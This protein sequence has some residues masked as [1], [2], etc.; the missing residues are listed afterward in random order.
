VMIQRR[1]PGGTPGLI[2]GTRRTEP[3]RS[4]GRLNDRGRAY[5][6]PFRGITYPR[7]MHGTLPFSEQQALASLRGG[8]AAGRKSIAGAGARVGLE[9]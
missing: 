3:A 4:C 2:H 8:T 1:P 7:T 9:P 5:H 6:T